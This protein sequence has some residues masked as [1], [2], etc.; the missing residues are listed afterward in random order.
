M[1]MLAGKACKA[2]LVLKKQWNNLVENYW[3]GMKTKDG[4]LN[5]NSTRGTVDLGT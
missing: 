2:P 5:Q 4:D 3:L 1:K